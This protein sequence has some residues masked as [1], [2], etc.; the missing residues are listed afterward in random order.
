MLR[1]ILLSI[2]FLFFAISSFA[3]DSLA[4]QRAQHLQRGINLSMWFAQASDYSPARLRTYTTLADVDRVAKM[5][6][7]HARIS[8]DPAIFCYQYPWTNCESVKILDDVVARALSKNVAVIIDVHPTSEYKKSIATSDDAAERF[9]QLWA[10]IAEHFSKSDP[11]RT[12]FEIMNEPE[13]A[14][15]FRWTGIQQ[16]A[17][18]AIRR[19]APN[20]TIIVGGSRYS[21][22][23]NLFML[24]DLAD[25]NVIFNFHYYSPHT[26]T[27]Q[28]ATWGSAYWIGL[29]NLPFPSSKVSPADQGATTDEARW[30][31]LQYKL[32]HWDAS[33]IDA[34]IGFAADWARQHH[35]P[36]TCN[37][38]GV[39]RDHSDP[40]DRMAWLSTVRQSLEKSKIGWTMWDYSG[41]FG[42]VTVKNGEVTEDR[43]VLKALGLAH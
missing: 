5:G 37:E 2:A 7:D 16:H 20:H 17:I 12:F 23:E 33:R 14:D 6:F 35:V 26:F 4:F 19:G 39:Y 10:H 25:R 9:A 3:Q 42:V 8:V 38:F 31:L 28:G 15:T 29:H 13:A 43:Q 11:D 40:E 18:V 30:Q 1:R 22:I 41:G 32:D 27:H 36:L 21:D 24:P 34:E